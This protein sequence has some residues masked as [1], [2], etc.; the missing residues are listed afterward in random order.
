MMIR[1]DDFSKMLSGELDILK[2]QTAGLTTKD[3]LLQ[4][5]P[6]GNCLNWVMGHLVVNLVE[7]LDVLDGE[8]LADLP[9][10][11]RYRIG[12][13]PIRGEEASVLALD[14]LVDLYE[15]LTNKIVDR[16]SQMN[17]D[18]FEE[19]IDFWQGKSRRGY[20]AFFYFFHNTFHLGQLEYLRN[21]AGKTEKVI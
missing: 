6:G 21:L 17:E 15:Q 14:N 1:V 3:S 5:Q 18:D 20:V 7:I 8:L 10:L 9:D 16:L 11:T 19:E 2:Q 4:P 12:S 13:E